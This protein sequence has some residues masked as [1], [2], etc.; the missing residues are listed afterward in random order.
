MLRDGAR[1]AAIYWPDPRP[2][3]SPV[4]CEL[5]RPLAWVFAAVDTRVGLLT[6]VSGEVVKRIVA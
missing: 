3:S 4:A 6:D 5:L 2:G 1:A